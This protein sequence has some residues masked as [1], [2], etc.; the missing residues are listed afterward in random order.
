MGLE[1]SQATAYLEAFCKFIDQGGQP[2]S[3]TAERPIKEKLMEINEELD[4][5]VREARSL[6]VRGGLDRLDA[7]NITRLLDSARAYL[8]DP[9]LMK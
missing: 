6:D 8:M 4:A 3:I 5:I 2:E 1:D 7:E 9:E